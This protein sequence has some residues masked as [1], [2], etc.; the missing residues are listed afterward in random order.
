MV[1]EAGERALVRLLSEPRLSDTDTTTDTDRDTEQRDQR[2]MSREPPQQEKSPPDIGAPGPAAA[3][4]SP[5]AAVMNL[6][7]IAANP[8]PTA[9]TLA[10]ASVE[11]ELSLRAEQPIEGCELF[12]HPYI[13]IKNTTFDNPTKAKVSPIPPPAPAS[14]LPTD[15]RSQPPPLCL[16]VVSRADDEKMSEWNLSQERDL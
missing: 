7:Q 12:P 4:D 10:L 6:A 9:L 13:K 3:Q 15:L 11:W 14:S 8:I 1:A 2:N 5:A 16:R